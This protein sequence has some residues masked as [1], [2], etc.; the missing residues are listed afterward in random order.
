MPK[1]LL[2]ADQDIWE[3]RRYNAGFVPWMT[4][5]SQRDAHLMATR[6]CLRC[7]KTSEQAWTGRMRLDTA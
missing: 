1:P 4:E 7:D 5:T 3:E 2:V 6:T